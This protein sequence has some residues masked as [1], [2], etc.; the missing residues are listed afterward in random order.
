MN[1]PEAAAFVQARANR[2]GRVLGIQRAQDLQFPDLR[3]ED[4]E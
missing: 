4:Q 2:I 1:E 3:A